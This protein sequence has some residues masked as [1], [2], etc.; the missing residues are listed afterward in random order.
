MRLLL[1]I[2]YYLRTI[3]I[4]LLNL[5]NPFTVFGYFFGKHVLLSFK[6]GMYLETTQLID[7]LI[8][9]ETIYYDDYR[10]KRISPDTHAGLYIIDVGAAL[11]DYSIFCA[12]QYPHAEIIAFEPNPYEYK[13]LEHNISTNKAKNI[14]SVPK[15]VSTEKN[16][17]LYISSSHVKTT[18]FGK[19]SETDEK[20]SVPAV[21]LDAYITRKVDMLKIDCEGAEIEILETISDEQFKHINAICIE[22]HNYLL[23]E[24]DTKLITMLTKKGYTLEQKQDFY[25]ADLG[26]IFAKRI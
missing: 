26:Y 23:P 2:P 18:L 11:G 10:V 14:I 12:R 13:L 7:P 8:I 17:Q 16:V 15:A 6:N 24:E 19:Q 1:K 25:N 9:V 3:F 22:Y 21:R 20:V 4:L 5:K